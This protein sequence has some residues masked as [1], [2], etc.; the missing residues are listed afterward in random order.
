VVLA[1]NILFAFFISVI[2]ALTPVIGLK[3]LRLQPC[4]LG[5]NGFG[6]AVPALFTRTSSRPKVATADSLPLGLLAL[7]TNQRS[8]P[9]FLAAVAIA[10]VGYSLSFLGGLN[11]INANAPVHHRGGTISAVLVIAYFLQGAVALLLGIAAK[12]W[13]LG[14]AIDLGSVAIDLFGTVTV[15]LALLNGRSVKQAAVS[16]ELL[17]IS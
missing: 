7:S 4:S 10:G 14:I 5:L 2:P 8:L 16:P 15:S 3:E 11:L 6:M 13:G 1:R 12:A 17:E 9:I